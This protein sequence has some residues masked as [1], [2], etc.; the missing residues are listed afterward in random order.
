MRIK[1]KQI[2]ERELSMIKIQE[3]IRLGL[4][5]K[6]YRSIMQSCN[7]SI[8][9]I[10]KYLKI[11]KEKQIT[12]EQI[13]N[14]TKKELFKILEIESVED[15]KN[16][17]KTP[18][19]KY[20]HD[21][22]K[23][24]HVTLFLLWQEYKD[25]NPDGYQYSRYCMLYNAWRKKLNISMRQ[26]HK[27]G[28]KMFVDYAGSKV[29]IY[30]KTTGKKKYESAIF[31]AC[32]GASNYTYVEATKNQ[33]V[34][35]WISSHI[36][37]FEYF[38]G[39]PEIVVCDNLKSGIKDAN[40]Y[41]PDINTTYCELARYYG[42]TIIPTRVRK[43]KDKAKVENAVLV[44]NRWIL[45]RL[46]KRRFYNLNE[47]NKEIA[48]LLEDLNTRTFK[49]LSGCRRDQYEIIDKPALKGLPKEPYELSIWKKAKVNIDYHIELEG[50]YYSVP[51]NYVQK[52]VEIRTTQRIVEIYYKNNRIASHLRDDRRNQYTTTV[53]HMP[54]SHREYSGWNKE[55]FITWAQKIGPY[56][57]EI[58]HIKL[59]SHEH[60]T[61]AFRGCLGILGLAKKFTNERLENAC[62]R[63]LRINTTSYKS[64]H[65]ILKH[66]LD[67]QELQENSKV[68]NIKHNNIRGEEYYK[69]NNNP[70][71]IKE[72]LECS[73]TQLETNCK[74]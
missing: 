46:R 49:K 30:D 73:F 9:V 42:T 33:K 5:G 48:K 58:I 12:Y 3:I 61:Q 40:F 63:A 4:D 39:V 23:N 21:E 62:R 24:K 38:K 14:L 67:K 1:K 43:P 6:S 22:L 26:I 74:N 16:L 72:V 69:T 53:D 7:V 27:A 56:T 50:H 71:S 59:N 57:A 41:E 52:Q 28:E 35:N 10:S 65:N 68:L 25:Q 20:I 32:L 29:P 15:I 8:G 11:A 70:V 60:V 47:L 2:N 17:K 19:F 34:A 54:K 44:V 31:I 18:N 66:N 13:K 64:I 51:F 45:A 37:S 36:N 55:R